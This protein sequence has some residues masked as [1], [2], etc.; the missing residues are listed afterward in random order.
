MKS[1]FKQ[2]AVSL[3]SEF[4]FSYTGCLAKAKE[5][6]LSYYLLRA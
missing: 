6:S 5:L 2:N 3:N 4:S 1:I